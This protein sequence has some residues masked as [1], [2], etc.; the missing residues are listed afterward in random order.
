M[1]SIVNNGLI[2]KKKKANSEISL[3]LQGRRQSYLS[4]QGLLISFEVSLHFDLFVVSRE[5]RLHIQENYEIMG[6]DNNTLLVV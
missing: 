3:Y 6:T 4:C 5:K 1:P 2:K